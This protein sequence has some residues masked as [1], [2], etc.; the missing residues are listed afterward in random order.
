MRTPLCTR[1]RSRATRT[2]SLRPMLPPDR[3][4]AF[5]ITAFV[6]IVVPG[7]SVLFVVDRAYLF[8]PGA[9][10]FGERGS[11]AAALAAP[12]ALRSKRRAFL[13][14][15]TV[16]VANPE[17]VRLPSRHPANSSI[18][19]PA[20][21]PGGLPWICETAGVSHPPS[22]A[23]NSGLSRQPSGARSCFRCRA[24]QRLPPAERSTSFSRRQLGARLSSERSVGRR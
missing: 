20:T 1:R 16:G 12:T 24:V 3:L 6:A 22:F 13:D 21:S 5:G 9:K 8:Y 4:L 11:L 2:L 7:P 18:A 17:T 14:G 10:T 15:W 19:G 23:G